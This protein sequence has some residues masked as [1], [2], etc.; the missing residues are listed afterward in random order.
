VL[1]LAKWVEK[2]KKRPLWEKIGKEDEWKEKILNKI[3]P[4]H[5]LRAGD[6][7]DQEKR[8]NEKTERKRKVTC[9][10]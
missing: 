1:K 4:Y 9:A 6:K 3:G 2:E 5:E 8:A 7:R 10:E